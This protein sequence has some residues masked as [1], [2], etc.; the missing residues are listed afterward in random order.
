MRRIAGVLLV[1]SRNW[2]LLQERDEHAPRFPNVWGMVGGHVEEGE[3]FETAAHR[4]LEEETGLTL[5]TGSLRLWRAHAIQLDIPAAEGRDE[6][7][8][9][10]TAKVDITDDDVS[11]GEGRQIVF[12]DPAGLDELE[13]ASHTRD[14]LAGFLAS[15]S[16]QSLNEAE[17]VT[18][19]SASATVRE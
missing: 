14:L 13:M 11:V 16:Y 12:V 7:F 18:P 9:V 2:V 5:P 4:E 6:H 10:Y 1:D 3:D 17:P 19:R 8:H 15:D